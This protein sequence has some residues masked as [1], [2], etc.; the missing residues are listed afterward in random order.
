MRIAVCSDTHD[1]IPHLR[2]AITLANQEGAELLIHCGDPVSPFMLPYL[3]HCNGKAHC[4]YG[5]KSG[6]QHPIASRC[7]QPGTIHH[8]GAHASL[9]AGSL[10]IAIVHYP[11]WAR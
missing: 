1:H 7:S 6:D 10:G 2:R 11:R 3:D 9:V 4:I 8:H 5:R